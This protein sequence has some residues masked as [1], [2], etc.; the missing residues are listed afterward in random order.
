MTAC[1][2]RRL[3]REGPEFKG[4]LGY[5]MKPCLLPPPLKSFDSKELPPVKT[6]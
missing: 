1:D 2:L 5:I 4:S 6:F 3:R